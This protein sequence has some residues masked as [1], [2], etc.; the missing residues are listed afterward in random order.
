MTGIKFCHQTIGEVSSAD[1]ISLHD[2]KGKFEARRRCA[3]QKK[4]DCC[5][6]GT[7]VH[8]TVRGEGER[9]QLGTL[10]NLINM[11]KVT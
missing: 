3:L 7:P 1:L 10:R 5:G 4:T 11:E 8:T 6:N 9:R 2:G